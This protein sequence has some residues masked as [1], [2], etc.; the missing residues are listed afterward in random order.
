MKAERKNKKM[1]VVS[2]TQDYM[3]TSTMPW[4]WDRPMLNEYQ[5]ILNRLAALD[6]K[7]GQPDCEDPAKAAWMKEIEKRLDAVEGRV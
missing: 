2:V 6:A 7:L 5:E 3:R 4:Q 1:C